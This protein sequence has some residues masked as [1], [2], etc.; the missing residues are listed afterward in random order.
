MPVTMKPASASQEAMPEIA[1][2]LSFQRHYTTAAV[3]VYDTVE[4]EQRQA[5]IADSRNTVIFQQ[6]AVEV[7][8]PWSQTATN[9]VASKYFHGALGTPERETSVRQLVHRVCDTIRTWGLRGGYIHKPED[10]DVFYDELAYLIIHQMASFNSPV[11]FNVGCDRIEPDSLAQSWHWNRQT[12]KV[13][14]ART[15]YQHPQCSA[16]FINSVNDTLTSIR[17]LDNTVGML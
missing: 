4:W 12:G 6:D 10:A 3:S 15:G 13:E 16:C 14:S 9:I 1:T 5:L 8:K 7:P 17:D 11:W 2:G